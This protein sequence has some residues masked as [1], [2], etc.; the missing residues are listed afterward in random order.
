MTDIQTNT[1]RYR[2]WMDHL[3]QLPMYALVTTG[4]TGSDFL[5]SLL[6]SHPQVATFN[7][8][9]AIYS[10]FFATS[11]CLASP[12]PA[13][14]DVTDEFIGQ[15]IYKLVSQYDTQ[16]GKDRLGEAFD[17]SFT[18]DTTQFRRHV[19]GLIGDTPV[20]TANFLLAV[21]GAYNLCLGYD[22]MQTRVVF[23]H[24]HLLYELELFLADFPQTALAFTTR[25]PRANFV[26]H[27]E[28]FRSYYC[29]NDNQQHLYQCM[30]MMLEDST[31]GHDL[32]LRYIAVRLEDL[33]KESTMVEFSRWLGIDFRDSL[34]HSTW[35]GLDWHG[36]RLS[37]K[38]F[39]SRGWSERR[40]ENN[41]QNRL[42]KID[43][44]VFS[45]IMSS[46][47]RQYRYAGSRQSMFAML[48]AALVIPLPM[49]YE[50]R[51]LTPAY[52]K[53]VFSAKGRIMHLQFLLTPVFYLKRILLCYRY[54][55]LE[56]RGRTGRFPHI[57]D[58]RVEDSSAQASR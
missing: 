22:L 31:P 46:R 20:T 15:Y 6:D 47:L 58:G 34:L 8:H 30:K 12:H 19:V 42:G 13:A 4:R 16:E 55:V 39:A 33:P 54:L 57:G 14:G 3:R 45:C 51:Y 52:L 26:S 32:G 28:H 5:Q 40:T 24:P 29:V 43:Q 17:Q 2:E 25:D 10:E 37:K 38:T 11:V 44:F 41:W 49:K 27:V 35:A 18:I 48:L 21:Y 23:H 36:D 53:Q 9:F 56:L 50:W 7:G 1:G